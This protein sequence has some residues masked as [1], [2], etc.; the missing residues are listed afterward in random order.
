[1]LSG[2][3][4]ETRVDGGFYGTV[5]EYSVHVSHDGEDF[6]QVATG[7]WDRTPFPKSVE[8]TEV[9]ARYLRFAVEQGVGGFSHVA[10]LTPYESASSALTAPDGQMSAAEDEVIVDVHS[11]YGTDCEPAYQEVGAWVTSNLSGHA[12]ATT[13]YSNDPGATATWT[14][15][16]PTYGDYE[17]SIW[18]PEHATT[19]TSATYTIDHADEADE[20]TIDPRERAGQWHI[21]GSFPFTSGRDGNVTLTV[22]EGYHR[23]DAVRFR[24][25]EDG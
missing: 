11:V 14:P 17:V 22:G 16:L 9:P 12:G 10:R 13:R 21:L 3:R 25:L 23:A 4:Y 19:T 7:S 18:W 2:L 1:M 15:E 6:D 8:L 5:T 20:I 24:A